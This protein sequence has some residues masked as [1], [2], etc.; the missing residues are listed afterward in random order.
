MKM[1]QAGKFASYA[2]LLA[3]CILLAA[4][5]SAASDLGGRLTLTFSQVINNACISE[6]DSGNATVTVVVSAGANGQGALVA[7]FYAPATFTATDT[8]GH[9][10][11]E[12]GSALGA[13]TTQTSAG[14]T[15]TIPLRLKFKG[16]NGAPTFSVLID[17]I[18]T[19]DQDQVP[20][21][22]NAPGVSGRCGS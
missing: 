20:I 2:S 7:A 14:H 16:Q 4:G 1:N 18:V 6:V 8:S 21:G 15:Y 12:T 19:V 5:P 13:F 3:G 9:V 17:E 11:Q 10:Y 22:L